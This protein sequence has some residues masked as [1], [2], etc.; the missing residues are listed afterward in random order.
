[1]LDALGGSDALELLHRSL[2]EL[3]D[4]AESGANHA[5]SSSSSS[6]SSSKHAQHAQHGYGDFMAAGGALH[7]LLDN[8]LRRAFEESNDYEDL[9]T[10]DYKK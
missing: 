2:D 10:N 7:A 9:D 5:S 1:M 6:S 3:L 4:A 8:L